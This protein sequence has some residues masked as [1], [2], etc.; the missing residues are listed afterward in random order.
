MPQGFLWQLVIVQPDIPQDG[1]LKFF[2]AMEVMGAQDVGDAPVEAFNHAVGL[3]VW[4]S[5]TMAVMMARASGSRP[6]SAT[7][8]FFPIWLPVNPKPRTSA[9]RDLA[10]RALL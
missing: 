2:A 5:R 10:A 3:R 9:W 6:S 8:V 7:I 4:A 1:G